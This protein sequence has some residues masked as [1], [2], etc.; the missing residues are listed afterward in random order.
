MAKKV[1]R[2]KP[3]VEAIFELRWQLTEQLGGARVDP[4][5]SIL[6]GKLYDRLSASYPFHQK[7]PTAIVP[8]EMV[9][10]VVQHRFRKAENEWPLVQ[11]GPGIVTLNDTEGYDWT[12][13]EPGIEGL[14]DALFEAYQPNTL[15]VSELQLRYIDAMSFDYEQNSI[16]AFLRDRMG[17][18]VNMPSDL[19]EGT[20]VAKS[21]R[22]FDW[23]FSF[24]CE[25][26]SGSIHLRFARGQ[27][28]QVDSLVW[29]MSVA[30]EGSV[31]AKARED[32]YAWVGRAHDLALDWFFKLI[33]DEELET[34]FGLCMV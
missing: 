19:F 10:H 33:R 32:I 20:A 26:P 15:H 28:N 34:R 29:E 3:L 12:T 31:L 9:A 8:E 5:Y 16:F 6:I 7:L 23:R 2:N 25:Q 24:P 21:P 4:N 13:F 22:S 18:D 30:S 17:V 14:V 11:I 1:L 27:R